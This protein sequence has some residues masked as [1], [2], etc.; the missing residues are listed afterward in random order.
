MYICVYICVKSSYK[1]LECIIGHPYIYI[2]QL[3]KI[4]ISLFNSKMK[5]FA[6]SRSN[7]PLR[8]CNK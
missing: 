4:Q 5:S 6:S 7:I 1:H 3:K 2:Y 8:M